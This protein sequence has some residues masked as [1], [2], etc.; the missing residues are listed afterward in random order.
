MPKPVTKEYGFN[1][2]AGCVSQSRSRITGTLVG[3]YHGEQ[4]GMEDDPE[5]PWQTVCEDHGS[6]VGHPSLKLAKEHAPDPSQWCEDC[7]T[8]LEAKT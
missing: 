7:R 5:I 6:I 4:S 8:A 2:L 3:I 1:D